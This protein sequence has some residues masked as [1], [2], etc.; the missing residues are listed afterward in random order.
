MSE[1]LSRFRQTVAPAIGRQFVEDEKPTRHEPSSAAEL[2][3][4]AI[5]AMSEGAALASAG[6]GRARRD[7]SINSVVKLIR[8]VILSVGMQPQHAGADTRARTARRRPVAAR[9]K[10]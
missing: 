5:I 2:V 3:G 10:R 8:E 7:G 4:H 6:Q 9:S 1:L